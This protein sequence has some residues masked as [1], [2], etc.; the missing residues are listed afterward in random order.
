MPAKPSKTTVSVEAAVARDAQSGLPVIIAYDSSFGTANLPKKYFDAKALQTDHGTA[1]KTGLAGA[2][3]FKNRTRAVVVIKPTVTAVAAENKGNATSGTLANPPSG[4][5]LPVVRV[6]GVA[7]TVVFKTET[8]AALTALTPAVGTVHLNP[9]TGEYEVGDAVTTGVEWDYS[10]I[11]WTDLVAALNKH[12]QDLGPYTY[13]DLPGLEA[14]LRN[15][16]DF[17]L[18]ADKAE[19][20]E[21]VVIGHLPASETVA[22]AKTL[23]SA[24]GS[25]LCALYAHKDTSSDVAALLIGAFSRLD[26]WLTR[27]YKR[28]T[29]ITM[30]DYYTSAEIGDVETSDTFEGEGINVIHRLGNK[31]VPT[32]E[33]TCMAYSAGANEEIYLS[34][35]L[36]QITLGQRINARLD[37]LILDNPQI[38]FNE[39]GVGAGSIVI[40]E[41]LEELVSEGAIFGNSDPDENNHYAVTDPVLSEISAAS[42]KKRSLGPWRVRA[43]MVEGAHELT[44]EA[45]L[46]VS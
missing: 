46:V 34:R 45:T 5:T 41:V 26:P 32:N 40:K 3:M 12:A 7:K 30:T 33:R 4:T 37:A 31:L 28:V 36:M 29:G 35:T 19:D 23:R 14:K 15:Y 39:K 8:G 18:A 11:N 13:L 1:T 24:I 2:A 16:G 22:N 25:S 42:K 44:T 38:G 20:N 9:Y 27:A 10:W 43:V 17:K 6:N 21:W